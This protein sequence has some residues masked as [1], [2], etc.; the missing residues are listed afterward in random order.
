LDAYPT[1]KRLANDIGESVD[2]VRRGIKVLEAHGLI[3]V[4]HRKNPDNPRM[5]DS[6]LYILKD[7]GTGNLQEGYSQDA[8]MDTR[9]MQGR[10]ESS[11]RQRNTQRYATRS[12]SEFD[13]EDIQAH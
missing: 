11:N 4:I 5:N 7:L 3:E 6:N 10:I 12:Y 2:T 9:N 1:V 13:D 8:S